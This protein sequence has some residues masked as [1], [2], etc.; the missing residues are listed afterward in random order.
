MPV[1]CD[2]LTVSTARSLRDVV[3]PIAIDLN[4]SQNLRG[5]GWPIIIF[6]PFIEPPNPFLR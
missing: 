6:Y 2:A 4:K 1:P 5:L 3:I